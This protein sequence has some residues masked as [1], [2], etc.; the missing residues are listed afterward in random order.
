M[1]LIRSWGE[2]HGHRFNPE[3]GKEK[4]RMWG[5]KPAPSL[6]KSTNTTTRPVHQLWW[7]N[8]SLFHIRSAGASKPRGNTWMVELLRR[9]HVAHA[10]LV[11]PIF[12][13]F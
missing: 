3:L 7:F 9:V 10:E 1:D 11:F 8:N 12:F 5:V 13:P 4:R 6:I 2:K